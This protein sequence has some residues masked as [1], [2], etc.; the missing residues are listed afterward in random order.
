MI[1][2]MSKEP[3]RI[4][5]IL[6]QLLIK[7]GLKKGIEQHK[8]LIIWNQVV[9]KGISAHTKPGWINNGIL[10]VIV[11]DSIWQQELEF[12]K[13]QIIEKINQHLADYKIKGIKFIQ[14]R[15]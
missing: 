4:S 7:L 15:S 8:A 2:S 12:L 1:K 13:P 9:G 14:K 6:P 3:E 5:N 11:D 10:W